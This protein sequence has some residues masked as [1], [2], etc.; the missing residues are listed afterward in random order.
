MGFLDK[1]LSDKIVNTNGYT[2]SDT[3]TKV[4]AYLRTYP[5]NVG[6]AKEFTRSVI[7]ALKK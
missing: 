7:K 5:K 6:V 1:I 2:R 4:H 3:G